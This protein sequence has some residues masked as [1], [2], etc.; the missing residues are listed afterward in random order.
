GSVFDCGFRVFPMTGATGATVV[1]GL[2]SRGD[3]LDRVKTNLSFL[4]SLFETCPIGLVMLDEELRYVHLN[5]ALADM[6]G[7]PLTEHLGRRMADVMITSDGGEYQ[8]MLR[9]V[10]DEGRT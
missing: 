5:Q 3:E 10:A 1:I 4:D 9:S 2:A 7:V 8:R 6:D